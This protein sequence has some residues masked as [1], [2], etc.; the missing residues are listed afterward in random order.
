MLY[1][2]QRHDI[3]EPAACAQ[4]RGRGRSQVRSA[5]QV[6]ETARV[7]ARHRHQQDGVRGAGEKGDRAPPHP[8]KHI[9]Y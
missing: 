2:L 3:G 6:A 7:L 8:L 1:A 9:C 4:P 5:R